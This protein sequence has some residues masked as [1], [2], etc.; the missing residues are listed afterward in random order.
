MDSEATYTGCKWR[1]GGWAH[2]WSDGTVLPV[3]R[4]RDEGGSG[5]GGDDEDEDDKDEGEGDDDDDEG[6]PD[7]DK[8]KDPIAK[9]RAETE[10]HW[11]HKSKKRVADAVAAA[12]AKFAR[13]K[14]LEGKA[15]AEKEKARREEVEKENTELRARADSQ[16]LTNAF[17]MA[18]GGNRFVEADVALDAARKLPE[19]K[20]IETDEEDGTVQGMDKV[21]DVL[22]KKKPYLLRKD[23]DDSAD[24][25][26]PSGRPMNRQRKG[27]K[28]T[29]ETAL[30][31]K[32][33]ALRR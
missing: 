25:G 29:D 30:M 12:E 1:N 15:E 11:R 20:D 2:T 18:G 32:Y 9:A 3:I 13:D 5:E 8:I 7:P 26:Q 6:E 19:W 21:L 24:E 17:L 22:A 27:K 33:P 28:E 16:A 4:G 23:D 10:A 31:K 14:E